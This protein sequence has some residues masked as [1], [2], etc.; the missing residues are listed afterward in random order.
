MP[1]IKDFYKILGIE[2]GASAD[3]IKKAYR[4]LALKYHPDRNP[5]DAKAEER[6]KEIQEAYEVLSDAKKH[7]Q[8]DRMRKNP[9]AGPFGD[10]FDTRTGG[11]FYRAP[12]GTYVRFDTGG[13][14]RRGT[15]GGF[16]EVFGDEGVLGGIGDIF[17]KVFG[18]AAGPGR[19]RPQAAPRGR[20]RDLDRKTR[21]RLSFE[22]ALK[23]GKT[24][25]PLPDGGKVRINIPKGVHDGFK[26]RLRG[27]GAAGTGGQQGDL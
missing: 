13:N 15:P 9:F 20:R 1:K 19:P 5:D 8:Y 25:V 14:G 22:E 2:E 24:E 6:F 16:G 26:V 4:K 23:G 10:A 27:R 12:D 18:G 3:E 17:S 11:R 7:K 21:V